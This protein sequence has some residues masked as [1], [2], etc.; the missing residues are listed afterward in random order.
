MYS[1]YNDY[2]LPQRMGGGTVTVRLRPSGRRWCSLSSHAG[3]IEELAILLRS[4]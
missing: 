4:D 3:G 1:W 2:Q